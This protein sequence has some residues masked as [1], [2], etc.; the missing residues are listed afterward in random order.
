MN[1]F[2]HMNRIRPVLINRDSPQFQGFPSPPQSMPV[3]LNGQ[4]LNQQTLQQQTIQLNSLNDSICLENFICPSHA[5]QPNKVYC[6]ACCVDLPLTA[7]DEH[8]RTSKHFNNRKKLNNQLL[9]VNLFQISKH[10]SH[11]LMVS[12]NRSFVNQSAFTSVKLLGIC[13]G[14][15]LMTSRSLEL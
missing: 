2:N 12:L 13:I 6:N 9:A 15:G 14:S 10:Y 4:L 8:L 3:R 5:K 11:E 1:Q 7:L